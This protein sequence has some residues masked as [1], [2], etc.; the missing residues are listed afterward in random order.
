MTGPSIGQIWKRR[1]PAEPDDGWGRIEV[2]GYFDQSLSGISEHVVQPVGGFESVSVTAA[3]LEQAFELEA[4]APDVPK[5]TI[6]VD[7]LNQWVA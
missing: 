4:A 5:P 7:S 2:V 1:T 3:D 6:G